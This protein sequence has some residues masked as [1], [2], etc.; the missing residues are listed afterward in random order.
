MYEKFCD[1]LYY[2]LTSPFKRVQKAVNQWYIFC[3]VFG[4]Y[5][6]DA[7][8]SLFTAVD[9]TMVATCRPE[10]LPI[11]AEERGI[12]RYPGESDENF[13]KRIANY[14]EVCRLGGSDAGVLLAVR[15][16]G[17]NSVSII[18][19]REFAP[20]RWA[21]FYVIINVDPDEE[22]PIGYDIVRQQVRK[23]KYTTARDNYQL[24]VGIPVNKVN[25]VITR[26]VIIAKS[27]TAGMQKV[28]GI[29]CCK[30]V[31]ENHCQLH[32]H[33]KNDL[34]YLDGSYRL[35]GTKILDAYET[36][37]DV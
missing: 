27:R 17:F 16:L 23:V 33:I 2:L 37:E 10:M 22:I 26:S 13:R 1:Y 14:A 21:E 34:W 29:I 30:I 31:N 19:A 15:S 25:T 20:E 5:F 9:Q 6:D 7:M 4:H 35:D 3:E 12:D 24:V 18:Q 32:V 28:K 36:R 8:E 11:Q